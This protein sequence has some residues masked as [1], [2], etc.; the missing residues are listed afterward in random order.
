MDQEILLRCKLGLPQ[1]W[2]YH[3]PAPTR[4]NLQPCQDY[5]EQLFKDQPLQKVLD[6]RHI[7]WCRMRLLASVQLL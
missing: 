3:Q 4:D 5:S 1:Y 2:L 7:Q 6:L